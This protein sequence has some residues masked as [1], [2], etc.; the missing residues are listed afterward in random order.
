L[1]GKIVIA[2]VTA[3]PRITAYTKQPESLE[4]ITTQSELASPEGGSIVRIF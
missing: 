1:K 3:L 2:K 4:L